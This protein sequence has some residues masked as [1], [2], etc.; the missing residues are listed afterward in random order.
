M[1]DDVGILDVLGL[2]V[3]R[4]PRLVSSLI[5]EATVVPQSQE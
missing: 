2:L 1:W 3:L 5:P 4:L